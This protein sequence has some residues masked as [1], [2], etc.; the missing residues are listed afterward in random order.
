M[1]DDIMRRTVLPLFGLCLCGSL[2]AYG[3]LVLT[4]A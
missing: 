4:G 3:V 1:E 2:L